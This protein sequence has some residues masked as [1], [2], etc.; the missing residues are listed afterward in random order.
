M[1]AYLNEVRRGLMKTKVASFKFLPDHYV[2]LVC[3]MDLKLA[4]KRGNCSTIKG[5]TRGKNI[6]WKH[7]PK[8][9]FVADTKN[10][11][12]WIA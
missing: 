10:H 6:P 11:E 8:S 9:L 4:R 1:S 7:L 3:Q 12:V 5:I 2:A